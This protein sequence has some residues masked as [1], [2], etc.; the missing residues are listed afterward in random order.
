MKKTIALV[1]LGA[2]LL[3]AISGCNLKNKFKGSTPTQTTEKIVLSAA[4]KEALKYKLEKD[5]DFN[6]TASS[7][8]AEKLDVSQS[9]VILS[10]ESVDLN[11]DGTYKIGFQ[12]EVEDNFR[13]TNYIGTF[14]VDSS[15]HITN[16]P[17]YEV[18]ESQFTSYSV[19][20]TRTFSY[21]IDN[22]KTARYIETYS[23]EGLIIQFILQK[24]LDDGT[25]EIDS[26]YYE[27]IFLYEDGSNETDYFI[28]LFKY[29]DGEKSLY[30]GSSKYDPETDSVTTVNLYTEENEDNSIK[31]YFASNSNIG[32]DP[33]NES[34]YSNHVTF[35]RDEEEN[36]LTLGTNNSTNEIKIILSDE[37]SGS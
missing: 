9:S 30:Y 15:L 36:T 28:L 6:N 1:V 33:T 37:D 18:S 22:E 4:T 27:T 25:R 35:G 34:L 3:S 31:D 20:P 8:L 11:E 2:F 26:A 12:A 16:G 19:V 10:I 23:L 14:D 5:E 29:T 24:S 32:S 13:Y 7:L 21:T 17:E